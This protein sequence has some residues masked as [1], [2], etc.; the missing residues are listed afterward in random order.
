MKISVT[1]LPTNYYLAGGKRLADW[2]QWNGESL[3]DSDF[4]VGA[5][6]EFR[7][8]LRKYLKKAQKRS[9]SQA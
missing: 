3:K 4:F 5:S 6:G 8:E 7:R 9:G 2:A 1:T